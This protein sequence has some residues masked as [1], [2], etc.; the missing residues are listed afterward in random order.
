VLEQLTTVR[1]LINNSL[2]V[3]DVSSWA[4]DYKNAS[5]IAGQLRLLSD[6]VQEARQTL[7]GEIP[8]KPWWED[9]MDE[10][11]II[12]HVRILDTDSANITRYSTHPSL[13]I[14]LFNSPSTTRQSP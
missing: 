10:K 13:A 14:S 9:P 8:I 6:N 4:G 7:K 2:D 12:V 5:F 1:T 11:V 3:I